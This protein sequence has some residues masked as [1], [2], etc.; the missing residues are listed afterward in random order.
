M[1]FGADTLAPPV[2]TAQNA[3]HKHVLRQ[4]GEARIMP[5]PFPHFYIENVF[6]D[7]FYQRLR[8]YF[9]SD[10][11]LVCLGDTGRVPAG[12]YKERF[13]Y[14][15]NQE[16]LAHLPDA[17]RAF[18]QDVASWMLGRPLVSL[19]SHKFLRALQTRFGTYMNE[20]RLSPEALLVRD[21]T[22]YSIGP[23]SDAPHRLLSML[24][25]CP[26]DN[27]MAHL[28]TSLYVPKKRGF[29]C[30]GGRHYTIDD[31]I[32][33][34][35]MPFLPN[36]AFCFL[37]TKNSFHGVEPITDKDICRDMLLYDIRVDPSHFAD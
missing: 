30:V 29:T 1:S 18:W 14:V 27:R 6:P 23:H 35:T 20:V 4:I 7:T 8:T 13:V 37:K 26:Q 5:N 32:N 25:Y 36:S 15:L 10:N 28:G 3:A 12:Q 17:K 19:L 22:N 16:N 9:P 34:G 24:F 11:E 33:V 21:R 31:F 2:A